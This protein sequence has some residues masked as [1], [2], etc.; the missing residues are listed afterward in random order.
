M[1]TQNVAPVY[2]RPPEY[3]KRYTDENLAI[4]KQV[5]EHGEEAFVAS[6]GNLPN[7]NIF[8]LEP[9]PPVTEGHY[10]SFK[11]KWTVVDVL[12][13]L[14]ENEQKQLYPSGEID[15]VAEFKKLNHSAIFNFLELLNSLVKEPERSL[16]KLEQIQTIFVNMKHML[17][18]YRPHRARETLRLMMRNQL[19]NRRRATEEIQ[20]RCSELAKKLE[21]VKS[22][23]KAMDELKMDL[24]RCSSLKDDL[25]FE[26]LTQNT[27]FEEVTD[28]NTYN[29]SQETTQK[30]LRMIDE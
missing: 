22:S 5:K 17:N 6:G 9:P 2:P 11:D 30:M 15:R 16:D 21:A 1:T 19:E 8:E 14:E 24:A 7:F 27:Q 28:P 25:D 23:W 10:F 20:K 18:E 29:I 26:I 13:S 12:P 3:Y 4:L